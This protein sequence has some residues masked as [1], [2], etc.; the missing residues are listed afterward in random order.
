[1]L[2][3]TV[4]LLSRDGE[5]H[6]LGAGLPISR[7]WSVQGQGGVGL[8]DVQQ[9][10]LPY[11][12]VDYEFGPDG[13]WALETI[14]DL[15]FPVERLEAVQLDYQPDDSW[16]RLDCL[17]ERPDGA[18]LRS[19]R[20]YPL[21]GTK[22]Q[23]RQWRVEDDDDR[24]R[25]RDWVELRP[26]GLEAARPLAAGQ[27]RVVFTVRRAGRADAGW[28]KFR[29]HYDR[30]FASVPFWRYFRTSVFLAL[31]NALLMTFA[32]ALA[33]YSFARLS[34]PGRN[35]CFVLLLATVLFPPQVTL[36]P[37]FLI[38]Q[39]LGAYNTLVPLWLP[40]AFGN[41][42]FIFLLYAAVRA[43]PPQLEDAARMDGC[44][45]FGVFWH[46]ALPQLAPSLAAIATF[47]FLAS[48]NDF[49]GP[50]LFLADQRLYPLSFGTYAL[51]VF[52]GNEPTLTAASAILLSLPPI[53]CFFLLQRHTLRLSIGPVVKG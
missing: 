7:R 28:S 16:H 11:A 46:A 18:G 31:A 30:V 33:A 26:S 48:W 2:L 36:V 13:A 6:E 32:S 40:A 14:A 21:A 52:S 49:L 9:G 17:V 23:S 1:L 38:W 50:L 43:M 29:F 34:W 44:G 27:V 42:F 4:R 3:G 19:T 5:E 47:S 35:L 45:P 24:P 39:Q 8:K 25:I 37:R 10:G 12:E 41:A 53:V 15:P 22:V 20:P 51:A